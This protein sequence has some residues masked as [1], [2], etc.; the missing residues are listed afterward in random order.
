MTSLF[1]DIDIQNL[2]TEELRSMVPDPSNGDLTYQYAHTWSSPLPTHEQENGALQ[3]QDLYTI[4]PGSS[5]FGSPQYAFDS[6]PSPNTNAVA[7]SFV[8]TPSSTT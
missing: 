8:A 4:S 2:S 1:D 7:G 3:Y 5:S 6:S